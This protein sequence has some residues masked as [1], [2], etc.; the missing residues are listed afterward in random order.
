MP[1]SPSDILHRHTFSML[2]VPGLFHGVYA[3]HGGESPAPWDSLNVGLHVGDL[4]AHVRTN[5]ARI[6]KNLQA[7]VL[8]SMHQVHGTK[9]VPVSSVPENDLEIPECDGLVTNLKN[10]G[11]MVQ[12]ADCQAVLFHD[13]VNKAVG[14]VHAG[15]RGSA[16]NII[17][18]CI[19]SMAD[20]YGTRAKE[21][22]AAISPSLGPCCSEFVN[23]RKELPPDLH[24][25]Q[26]QPD[27]FDF[28]AISRSQLTS[29]GVLEKNISIAEVCTVCSKD[30][31][32]YRRERTTGRFCSIIGL[33]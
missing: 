22:F 5:R 21:L 3:R 7:E 26:V 14:I 15:W 12:Q 16:G 9:I 17:E 18:A 10:V 20:N 19:A 28:W 30:Y 24:S 27:Y 13:P 31:F 8:V 1:E 25:F 33:R 29:S 23:Y 2:D 4:A 32:S 11:L 6:K